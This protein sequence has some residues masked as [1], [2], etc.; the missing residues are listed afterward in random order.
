[1]PKKKVA[2]RGRKPENENSTMATMWIPSEFKESD[3]VKAKKEG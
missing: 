1:M 2:H 3:L